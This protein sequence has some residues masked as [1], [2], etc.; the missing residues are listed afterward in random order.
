MLL[1][2]LR[3]R[4]VVNGK[5][6]YPLPDSKPVVVTV[7]DNNPRLVITDGYHISKPL[8]LLFKEGDTCC[9]KVEC[10]IND[11]QLYIGMVLLAFLYLSGFFTGFL[12]L[13]VLSFFPLLYL[14]MFYYLNRKDFFRLI[15]VLN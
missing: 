10:A 3:I 2:F 9:F 4:A 14:L 11:R 7:A 5:Q 6:I 12:L 15:P 13:K 8:K 1:S